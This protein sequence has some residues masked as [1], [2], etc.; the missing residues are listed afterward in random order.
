MFKN[1]YIDDD[2]N[3]VF[4]KDNDD[5]VIIDIVNPL[6]TDINVIK[7]DVLALEA[8]PP[9]DL[10]SYYTSTQTETVVANN[11]AGLFS[12]VTLNNTQLTFSTQDGSVSVS[13]THLTL[14]T[15]D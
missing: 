9:T 8:I 3:L 1:C 5:T 4:V 10:S 13:Y 11:I 15:T 2:T 7:S 12:N 14:P 6:I